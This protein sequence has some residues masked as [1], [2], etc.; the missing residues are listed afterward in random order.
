MAWQ[1]PKT[2]W[3]T[4]NVPSADDFNRIEENI[5]YLKAAIE[6]VAADITAL[7]STV[8]THTGNSSIHQTSSQ[9]RGDSSTRMLIEVRDND[10]AIATGKIWLNTSA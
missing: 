4:G 8:S 6:S 9:V 3:E 2:N 5:A 10:P 1:T 7:S